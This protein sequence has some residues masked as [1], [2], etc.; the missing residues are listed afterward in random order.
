MA[1]RRGGPSM[2][3]FASGSKTEGEN[4]CWLARRASQLERDCSWGGEGGQQGAG[5]RSET[6]ASRSTVQRPVSGAQNVRAGAQGGCALITVL[7]N[8]GNLLLSGSSLCCPAATALV[9][10]RHPPHKVLRGSHPL[11]GDCQL[12]RVGA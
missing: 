6:G 3:R 2:P 8:R 5:H 1:G 4:G 11:P 9:P 10:P 12:C 7:D